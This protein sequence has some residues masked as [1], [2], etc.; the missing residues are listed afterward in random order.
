M[1]SQVLAEPPIY[2]DYMMR[3]LRE[4]AYANRTPEVE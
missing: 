1:P 3:V 2:Q 4:E